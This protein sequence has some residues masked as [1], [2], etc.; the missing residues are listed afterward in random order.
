[1]ERNR[2]AVPLRP[3]REVRG[4]AEGRLRDSGDASWSQY[5]HM[6]L[7]EAIDA[8]LAREAEE[9]AELSSAASGG[10]SAEDSDAHQTDWPIQVL[11]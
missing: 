10:W 6:K 5:Q 1:M 4:W 11:S 8:I 3:L 2:Q 9:L 7:I